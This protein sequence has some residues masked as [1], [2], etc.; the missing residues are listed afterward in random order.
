V[1]RTRPELISWR[2]PDAQ[3]VAVPGFD[4]PFW[5]N[6]RTQ[7]YAEFN[8]KTPRAK[9]SRALVSGNAKEIARGLCYKDIYVDKGAPDVARIT[10]QDVKTGKAETLAVVQGPWRSAAELARA[11]G[12]DKAAEA[13]A[14]SARAVR[15][16]RRGEADVDWFET[17]AVYADQKRRRGRK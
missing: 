12:G 7:K 16:A 5:V 10:Y 9:M 2:E 14:W 6:H 15:G 1:S 11:V 8:F 17:E 13:C 3:K 4:Q